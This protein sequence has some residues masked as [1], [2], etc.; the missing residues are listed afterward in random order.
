MSSSCVA[1]QVDD[2][3]PQWLIG[4]HKT[5]L[6][7]ESIAAGM[8]TSGNRRK[9]RPLGRGT[10]QRVGA[11]RGHGHVLRLIGQPDSKRIEQF[12]VIV[13]DQDSEPHGHRITSLPLDR[14]D[15]RVTARSA[16]DGDSRSHDQSGPYD[17][18]TFRH[19]ALLRSASVTGLVAGT[20]PLCGWT[21][22]AGVI[23]RAASWTL[24][25][26]HRAAGSL[27]NEIGHLMDRD[28]GVIGWSLS[29]TGSN[30]DGEERPT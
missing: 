20:R 12:R 9:I 15:R 1:G 21:D 16:P 18:T 29:N 6:H 27:D 13:G 22:A 3:Y 23:G 11:V 8:F 17:S 4:A 28:D 14:R 30:L 25:V 5:L 10:D 24:A 7:A 26:G 2:R 19:D